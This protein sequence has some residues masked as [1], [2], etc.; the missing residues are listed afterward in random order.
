[1]RTSK[2][3]TAIVLF[4]SSLITRLLRTHLQL[5]A[6]TH[7]FQFSLSSACLKWSAKI[8]CNSFF[9]PL[10]WVDPLIYGITIYQYPLILRR[11]SLIYIYILTAND[12]HNI[13]FHKNY[14]RIGF[15]SIGGYASVNHLHFQLVY[16]DEFFPEQKIFPIEAAKTKVLLRSS[17][18]TKDTDEINMVTYLLNSFHSKVGISSIIVTFVII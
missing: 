15:N 1:M 11:N 2:K 13:F 18:Q 12:I 8:S 17:L 9:P 10:N 4:Q 7:Y 6:S 3:T 5:V 14:F 16:A